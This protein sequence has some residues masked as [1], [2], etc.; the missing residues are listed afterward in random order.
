M[1]LEFKKLFNLFPSDPSPMLATIK[2]I[3]SDYIKTHKS[4][5][6]YCLANGL[7]IQNPTEL[8]IAYEP[9][10]KRRGSLIEIF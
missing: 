7:K 1:T 5:Q 8:G 9:G 6:I 10:P 2:N 4:L 3:D